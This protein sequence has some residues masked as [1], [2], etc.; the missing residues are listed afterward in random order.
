MSV[1]LSDFF[2]VTSVP[3]GTQL[4]STTLADAFVASGVCTVQR[5]TL[6]LFDTLHLGDTLAT[7][8][9]SRVSVASNV[10]LSDALQVQ[11][12]EVLAA[13][14]TVHDSLNG[15][16][17]LV[18]A[19][20]D[21]LRLTATLD[22]TTHSLV[23]LVVA[24]AL[25]DSINGA[26]LLTRT[27]AF[28]FA[29]AVT[30]TAGQLAQLLDT[31]VADAQLTGRITVYGILNDDVVLTGTTNAVASILQALADSLMF[32]MTLYTGQD[33]WNAWVMTPQTRAMRS[34]TNYPYN[35]FATVGGRLYGAGS[36]GLYELTGAT[37]NGTTI[38]ASV[39]SGL[40]DFGTRQLK[41]MNAAYLGYTSSGVPCMRVCVTSPAGDKQ[42]YVYLATQK[43]ATDPRETRVK[44]GRG[45]QSV[46][47]QFTLDNSHDAS[48]FTFYEV[49]VLPLVLSRRIS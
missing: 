22:H 11:L 5:A 14:F 43:T 30:S 39:R 38:A 18:A 45:L 13:A 15:W 19:V 16:L 33:T 29:D 17:K 28:L 40:M 44:F 9:N 10:E 32:G 4:A 35:S 12:R 25:R 8:V 46:F 47:W 27:D 23:S 24:L 26:Q 49:A 7:W 2:N 1:T 31:F 37:D 3:L 41:R 6:A 21:L 34:Y 48:Q 36:A 42:E 20:S